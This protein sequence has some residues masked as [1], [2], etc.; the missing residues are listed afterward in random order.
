[1]STDGGSSENPLTGDERFPGSSKLGV[2]D[3]IKNA[4]DADSRTYRATLV[5]DTIEVDVDNPHVS[6][7]KVVLKPKET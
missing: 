7:Y 2:S 5:V 3:A 6:E 4:V 1:M